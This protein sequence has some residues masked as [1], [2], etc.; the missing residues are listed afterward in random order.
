[1]QSLHCALHSVSCLALLEAVAASVLLK[2]WQCK[3]LRPFACDDVGWHSM[4]PAVTA[5]GL[6]PAAEAAGMPGAL[7][8]A[9]ISDHGQTLTQTQLRVQLSQHVVQPVHVD[10]YWLLAG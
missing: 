3:Q 8:C 5:N 1:M 7:S 4:L 9:I 6:Q 10:L 2:A